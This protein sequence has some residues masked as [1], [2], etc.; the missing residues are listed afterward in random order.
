MQTAPCLIE[1]FHKI[2]IF[3]GKIAYTVRMFRHGEM[4]LLPHAR[5]IVRHRNRT[6]RGTHR[7]CPTLCSAFDIASFPLGRTSVLGLERGTRLPFVV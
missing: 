6:R 1:C 4:L 3:F 5:R 7:F 2:D